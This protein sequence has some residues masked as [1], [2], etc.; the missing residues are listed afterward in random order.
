MKTLT[1]NW[2][3]LVEGG[4]TCPRCGDTGV[5]VRRAAETLGRALAPLGIEVVLEEAELKLE[6]FKRQP[7]QSNRILIGGRPIEEWLG[8]TAGQSPCCE[9]CG[10]N[11]CRTLTVDGQTHEAIPADLVVRAGL[12]AAA[13]LTASV[14]EQ[15][16]CAPSEAAPTG[17]SCCSGAQ[18]LVGLSGRGSRKMKIQVLGTGCTKCKQLTANA[19]RAVAELGLAATVEKVEDLREIMAFGVMTTPALLVD[20]VVKAAGKVLSPEAVKELLRA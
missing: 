15:S 3:R 2:Q 12:L 20:G 8:G 17:E 13:G 11:D 16:C 7:L 5:Q 9:V 14:S 10:P 18:P 4:A 1:I 19:E 6:E